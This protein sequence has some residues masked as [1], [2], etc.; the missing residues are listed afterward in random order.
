MEA[1]TIGR[2]RQFGPG[3]EDPF[4]EQLRQFAQTATELKPLRQAKLRK[5]RKLLAVSLR[6]RR[7]AQFAPLNYRA[8]AA[9][10]QPAAP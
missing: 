2:L 9:T 8:F 6:S 3:L 7:P 5:Q 1:S 10:H 4:L